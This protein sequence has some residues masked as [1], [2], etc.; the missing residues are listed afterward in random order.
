VFYNFIHKVAW[1]IVKIWWSLKVRGKEN[2]PDEGPVIIVSNH[3]SNLDPVAIALQTKRHIHFLAKQE[4]AQTKITAWFFRHLLI[5]PVDR[6][7]VSPKTVK[8]CLRVLKDGEVLGIY[9]EGTRVK[10]ERIR[11]MNGFVMF[12][13]RT[14]AK[15]VPVHV[16]GS[17]MSFRS[18]VNMVIGEPFEL[19]EYYGQRLKPEKLDEIS[20]NIMDN[21]YN[22]K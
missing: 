10:G 8:E 11:P 21:I 13:I 3:Q 4:L 16:Q 9:P 17:G 18:K 22:L 6:K 14:Q 2:I 19:S 1:L 12:A 5:I 7:K 15:I 20:Q